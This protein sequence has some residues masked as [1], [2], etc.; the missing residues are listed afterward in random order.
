[1]CREEFELKLKEAGFENG[2][3][4][5][6]KLG[7]LRASVTEWHKHKYPKYVE[8]ILNYEIKKRNVIL[9]EENGDDNAFL[10]EEINLYKKENLKLKEQIRELK[11]KLNVEND[12]KFKVI[13]ENYSE[14][15]TKEELDIL[16]AKSRIKTC[17]E[18]ANFFNI[19]FQTIFSWN[20]TGKYPKYLKQLLEWLVYIKECENKW[21]KDSSN[22]LHNDT[23]NCKNINPYENIL[24]DEELKTLKANNAKLKQKLEDC[25]LME[26]MLKE[27]LKSR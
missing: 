17:V 15:L 7:I 27:K 5:A 6:E 16:L 1:M 10:K 9:I 8:C 21:N 23:N 13:K 3:E 26:R 2:R 19:R 18:L 20:K 11:I 25:I 4:F 22:S 12:E 14:K 24:K